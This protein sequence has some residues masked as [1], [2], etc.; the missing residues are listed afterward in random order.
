MALFAGH[1]STGLVAVVQTGWTT[2]GYL[3]KTIKGNGQLEM[4]QQN[5]TVLVTE[6][7]CK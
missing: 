4:Q 1:S 7:T 2:L 3:W 6:Q 5:P